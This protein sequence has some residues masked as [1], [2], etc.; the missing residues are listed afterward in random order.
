M[1]ILFC[2]LFHLFCLLFKLAKSDGAK[3]LAAE[4][5]VLR[6]QLLVLA[7][8]YKRASKLNSLERLLFAIPAL[9]I[10][11][12]R[13]LKTAIIIKPATLLRF[14][15]VLVEHKYHLLYSK[16]IPQKPGPKGPSK[17]VVQLVITMKQRNPRFGARRIAMQISNI[18]GISINKDAVLR[19]LAKHYTPS[20]NNGPS[21]LTFIGHMKDSLWSIDFFRA[22]SIILKSHWIMVIMDQFSRRII[23]FATHCGDLNGVAICCMSRIVKSIYNHQLG[24]IIIPIK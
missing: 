3:S 21:W 2:F 12:C 4:N 7:R 8:R 24:N 22:E 1:K 13:I 19:I 16:K 17:Q 11:P 20:G 18:F 9:F 14:H 15:K 6:Q 23:G 5:L 10:K